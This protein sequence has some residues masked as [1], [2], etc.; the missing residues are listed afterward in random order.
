MKAHY[1]SNQDENVNCS[2]CVSV[3]S[4]AGV[5]AVTQDMTV[6]GLSSGYQDVPL[7]ILVKPCLANGWSQ[8]NVPLARSSTETG[9]GTVS[10]GWGQPGPQ[11]W[12]R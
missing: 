7:W 8:C 5:W 9:Q 1:S 6:S 2:S 3:D 12:A 10:L 11:G 4:E